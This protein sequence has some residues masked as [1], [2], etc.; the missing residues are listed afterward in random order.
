MVTRDRLALARR[1]TACLAQQSHPRCE[2][3][4]VDDGKQSYQPLVDAY[5]GQLPIRYHRLEPQ[6]GRFLGALRNVALDQAQGEYCVQ[7]DDD[8]WYHP[9]R[10]EM[11]LRELVR[12][13]LDAVLLR[14]TLMHLDEPSFV[15]F[16]YRA[17]A[18]LGTPGTIFHRKTSIRYPNLPRGE[19]SVFM[20]AFAQ[21]G[22]I[23]PMQEAHSHLFMR[24]FHGSN[25]WERK[26]F[27]KRL[28]RRPS[29]MARYAWAVYARRD[30][31]THPAFRL[32]AEER[33]ATAHFL[34]MSQRLDLLQSL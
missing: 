1:A 26:H 17:D 30:I 3:V 25:T 4:I 28:R 9:Q 29:D 22:R 21:Q 11:Q 19:D 33:E 15:R 27:L 6:P 32:N 10:I 5:A 24:C 14:W 20:R 12:R 23:E 31:R 8:E 2:L 7:W 16:P 13:K 34:R 18:G